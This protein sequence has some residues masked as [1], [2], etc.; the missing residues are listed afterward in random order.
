MPPETRCQPSCMAAVRT[1]DVKL[2]TSVQRPLNTS[3]LASAHPGP[4]PNI[5]LHSDFLIGRVFTLQE[6]L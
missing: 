6:D 3:Q 5:P 2:A 1:G 4:G